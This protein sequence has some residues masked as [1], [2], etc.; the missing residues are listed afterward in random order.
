MLHAHQARGVAARPAAR[1]G[2]LHRRVDPRR[3]D[4]A[5]ADGSARRVQG[6]QAA[7]AGRHRRGRARPR[8]RHAA[9]RAELRAAARSG[10]LHPPHRPHR[11]CRGRGRGD[12]V[13]RA[14][15]GEVPH[16][17]RAA[18]EEDGA[19]RHRRGLR[20]DH[21]AHGAARTRRAAGAARRR[22]AQRASAARGAGGAGPACARA[23]TRRA[24][25]AARASQRR[26]RGAGCGA[27]APVRRRAAR[28]ARGRV[29]AQ[30]RPAA[31]GGG[32]G[33]CGQPSRTPIRTTRR[34]PF[35]RC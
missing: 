11:P 2:R 35:R 3:Q 18:A 26:R 24:G 25:P 28:G 29:R 12:R 4:A 14:G 27:R 31:A 21:R 9:A 16:R 17:D 13:R 7:G 22:R 34:D 20:R 33:E 19:G 15:G 6:R 1:E 5:G 8:H 10:R 32:A 30:S 23:R